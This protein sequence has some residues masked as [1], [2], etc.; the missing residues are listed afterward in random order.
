MAPA[1]TLHGSRIGPTIITVNGVSASVAGHHNLDSM[2]Y[3]SMDEPQSQTSCNSQQFMNLYQAATAAAAASTVAAAAMPTLAPKIVDEI[4]DD[5]VIYD[6]AVDL[7]P[8]DFE[9]FVDEPD[10][11][12]SHNRMFKVSFDSDSR[13]I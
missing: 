3:T 4:D 2:L 11:G 5:V 6:E 12:R 8:I 10:L 1:T 9:H 7:E 13:L